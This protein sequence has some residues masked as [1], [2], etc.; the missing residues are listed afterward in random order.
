MAHHHLF[1]FV[2]VYVEARHDDH[3]FLAVDDAG[4]AIRVDHGNV[5]GLEPAFGVQCLGR[6]LGLLPV[7]LHDLRALDAQ[8]AGFPQ[9]QL[10]A[11][12]VDHL[13]SRAHHRDAHR[14]QSRQRAIGVGAGHGRRFGQAVPFDDAAA[15][16]LFPALC[17]GLD[18]GGAA[19]IGD[20]ECGEIELAEAGVVHQR[21]EQG[22]EA[23][24]RRKPPLAQLLDEARYVPRVGDQYVVVAGDHHAHA[25]RGECID[26]VER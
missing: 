7:A 21:D 4:K 6:G 15:C 14:A 5:T 24:Q 16:Q 2:G 18:Q 20:L 23:Q 12:G 9:C 25:V 26:V 11:V 1:D 22:V 8:L 3:V 19:G 17:R 13:E 10:V